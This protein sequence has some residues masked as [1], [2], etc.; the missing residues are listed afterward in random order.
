[1]TATGDAVRWVAVAWSHNGKRFATASEEQTVK[2]WDISGK[3]VTILKG[4]KSGMSCVAWALYDEVLVAGDN[5]DGTIRLW[6]P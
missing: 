5:R 6:K 4:D 3:L 2:L 1:M